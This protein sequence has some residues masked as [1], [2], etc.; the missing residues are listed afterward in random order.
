MK[1]STKKFVSVSSFGL[2]LAVALSPV[3]LQEQTCEPELPEATALAN[4]EFKPF[5]MGSELPHDV[6]AFEAGVTEYA[7]EIP[8]ASKEA[9]V[10]ADPE[11]QSSTVSVQCIAGG[12]IDGHVCDPEL[13]WTMIDLPE[14]DLVVQVV[15]RASPEEGSGTGMYTID[16]TRERPDPATLVNLEFKPFQMGSELPHDVMTF[17]RGVTEYSVELPESVT[18]AMVVAEPAV[19]SSQRTIQCIAGGIIDGHAFDS[20]LTWTMIEVPEGSSIVQVFVRA[21]PEEGSGL[22]MYTIYITREA[23]GT[24]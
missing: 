6:L 5:Q 1:Y 3:L 11:V 15:V 9:M 21:S 18:Q 16:V 4:L 7:V 20:D 10:V 13:D 19:L 12:T 24:S 2:L 22:G 23:P 8:I 17:Q 14:G